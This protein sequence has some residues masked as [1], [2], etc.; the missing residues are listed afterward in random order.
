MTLRRQFAA[1]AIVVLPVALPAQDPVVKPRPDAPA[2]AGRPARPATVSAVQ[3]RDGRIEVRWSSVRG[4]D[5]YEITRSVPPGGATVVRQPDPADTVFVDSD[6]QA[7]RTYYYV[8]A[9]V[10]A[11]GVGIKAGAQPVRATLG[12]TAGGGGPVEPPVVVRVSPANGGLVW[13]NI[14]SGLRAGQTVRFERS[15]LDSP[16]PA[17]SPSVRR[18]IS[19]SGGLN[20]TDDVSSLAAG[21][22]VQWR[23]TVTDDATGVR[24]APTLSNVLTVGASTTTTT[25]TASPAADAAGAQVL[26]AVAPALSVRAGGTHSLAS[27][28]GGL[29]WTA[30]DESVATVDATG[31]AAA[32]GAGTA[33]LVGVGR[34][35]DGAV[36]VTVVR[37]TVT[38]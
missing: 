8:V 22:R 9:G 13:L 18:S 5:R 26:V 4:A 24:S 19:V 14:P 7:G 27:L 17:W 2:A 10:N 11:A 37:L 35:A 1:V 16:S 23:A 21:T 32:R 34:A 33:Q 38:P 28:G 12:V 30:L 6:V 20:V 36:R 15:L 29:R 25:T 3:R 31:T